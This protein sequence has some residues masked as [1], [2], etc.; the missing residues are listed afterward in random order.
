MSKRKYKNK[1]N[2]KENSNNNLTNNTFSQLSIRA[3]R[4]S[5]GK[6]RSFEKEEKQARYS[7]WDNR[8]AYC[9]IGKEKMTADH[10]VPLARGGKAVDRID[11]IVPAC[12]SCNNKKDSSDAWEWYSK[13]TFFDGSRWQKILDNVR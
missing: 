10:F 8:C 6:R 4:R 11:N 1:K 3:K 2:K 9:N 7:L 5:R 12:F 13:Q